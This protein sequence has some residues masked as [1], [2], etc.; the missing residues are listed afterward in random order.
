MFRKDVNCRTQGMAVSHVDKNVNELKVGSSLVTSLKQFKNNEQLAA[1]RSTSPSLVHTFSDLVYKSGQSHSSQHSLSGNTIVTSAPNYVD[2]NHNINHRCNS[3]SSQPETSYSSCL[4]GYPSNFK[5]IE[6]NFKR[7]QDSASSQS[8]NIFDNVLRHHQSNSLEHYPLSPDSSVDVSCHSRSTSCESGHAGNIPSEMS[9]IHHY[10]DLTVTDPIDFQ[11]K[12]T[13]SDRKRTSR[14]PSC[15]QSHSRKSSSEG[16]I[17]G[18]STP[19]KTRQYNRSSSFEDSHSKLLASHLI[20]EPVFTI[21]AYSC[22][23]PTSSILVN[24][25]LGPI[26][27][28]C[29]YPQELIRSHPSPLHPL[30]HSYTDKDEGLVLQRGYANDYIL[31]RPCCISYPPPFGVKIKEPSQKS[32]DSSPARRLC[33]ALPSTSSI[34][35]SSHTSGYKPNRSRTSSADNYDVVKA[36]V[37]RDIRDIP[38]TESIDVSQSNNSLN[39]VTQLTPTE[40]LSKPSHTFSSANLSSYSSM[41]HSNAAVVS[42]PPKATPPTSTTEEISIEIDADLISYMNA[43]Y[44]EPRFPIACAVPMTDPPPYNGSHN[45]VT[46]STQI[47]NTTDKCHHLPDPEQW[48]SKNVVSVNECNEKFD[49]QQ[50]SIPLPKVDHRRNSDPSKLLSEKYATPTEDDMVRRR[51]ERTTRISTVRPHSFTDTCSNSALNTCQSKTMSQDAESEKICIKRFKRTL[52]MPAVKHLE[53]RPKAALHHLS[54]HEGKVAPVAKKTRNRKRTDVIDSINRRKS[55]DSGT[56]QKLA[57]EIKT[58]PSLSSEVPFIAQLLNESQF[59]AIERRSQ[60]LY[61]HKS[62]DALYNMF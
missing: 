2:R 55:I 56:L 14:T 51:S 31:P 27:S 29:S 50:Q 40:M 25:N 9:P 41:T 4:I 39:H 17:K 6:P 54:Y 53:M 22:N 7:P 42:T 33:S 30:I 12:R 13:P 48:A 28:S 49:S 3:F 19:T 52:S 16:S 35:A 20:S 57:Q 24:H 44:S 5:Y 18:R 59:S 8:P 47:L 26:S 10:T 46:T 45:T 38:P 1:L 61:R 60:Y 58:D 34:N 62:T 21:D 36:N 32:R 11:C 15:E 37:M 43:K 23:F